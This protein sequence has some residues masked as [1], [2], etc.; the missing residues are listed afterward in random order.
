LTLLLAPLAAITATAQ[1]TD[2]TQMAHL[3]AANQLGTL[4]ITF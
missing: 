4:C 2:P 1:T 3:S